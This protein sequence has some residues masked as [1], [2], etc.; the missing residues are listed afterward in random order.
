M[1][2][3]WRTGPYPVNATFGSAPPAPLSQASRLSRAKDLFATVQAFIFATA[4]IL[5][6]AAL[7]LLLFDAIAQE[8]LLVEAISTPKEMVDRGYTK[9]ILAQRLMD[10]IQHINATSGTEKSKYEASSISSSVESLAVPDSAAPVKHFLLLVRKYLGITDI[11]IAGEMVCSEYPC[12]RDKLSLRLRVTGKTPASIDVGSIG[13]KSDAQYLHD[14]AE[15]ILREVD[16]YVYASYLD[17]ND[18]KKEAYKIARQIYAR[19]HKERNGG[20]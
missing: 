17:E 7:C 12:S 2:R 3:E 6:F 14:A 20:H 18:R 11:R 5:G 4:A 9:E 15:Q 19:G 16:P 10:S 8:K 1:G 13:T